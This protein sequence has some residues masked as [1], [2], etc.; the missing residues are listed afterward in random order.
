MVSGQKNTFRA[1]PRPTQR[2][3]AFSLPLWVLGA[4][5]VV[6]FGVAVFAGTVIFRVVRDVVAAGPFVTSPALRG[7]DPGAA[8][9]PALPDP[10]GGENPGADSGLTL[11][12][13]DGIRPENRVTVLVLGIDQPCV[14]I[15]EP[16]RSDT[17]ILLT[18]DP[19]SKTAGMLSVPR[20]LWVPIPGFGSNRINTAYRMGEVSEYPGGGGPALAVETVEYNLG[21]P[22]DYYLTVNYDAFIQVIDVIGGI[23]LEV[24]ETINHPEYPDRCYGYDPFYLSAGHHLM[25]GETALKYARTRA[26]KG[27]DFDRAMRQQT[28]LMA[29]WDQVLKQNVSL[30]KRAPEMWV[31]LQEN[32]TTN[33]TYQEALGLGL[34]ALEIPP[35]N[36]H[37]AAIDQDYVQD[38]TVQGGARVLVPIRERISDLRDEFFS[39]AAGVASAADLAAQMQE[40]GA[41]ILVLNGT[42][43]EGLAGATAEYLELAGFTIAGV[44][45]G[46]EKNQTATQI[47]DYGGASA[48]V[49][50]LAYLLDVSPGNIY[51]GTGLD[52]ERAYDVQLLL[53][54]SWELPGD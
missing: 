37:R 32:V 42:W 2:R 23:E 9:L 12:L 36:I 13:P 22:I 46:E 6:F 51:G 49:D 43:K 44:G 33:M 10:V 52:A 1:A 19:L 5:G 14:H 53:G 35:G 38:W 17:M 48:T 30:L 18:V 54:D 11:T 25:D 20:D 7:G 21:I 26:T 41:S 45:D 50:Y 31:A 29:A 28:V 15:E 47:I 39:T 34:L 27:A 40:E 24:P 3:A 16:N 4:I 8:D